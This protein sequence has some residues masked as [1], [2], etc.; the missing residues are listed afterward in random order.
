MG[1]QAVLPRQ[2]EGVSAAPALVAYLG[3]AG[4]GN[5]GDDAIQ[6]ALESAVPGVAFTDLPLYPAETAR[7]VIAPSGAR[8]IRNAVLLLGG[9]TVIGRSNWRV[10][11]RVAL[12]LVRTRP[13]IMIGSG[14]EDPAFQGRHSFAGPGELR[15][16]SN[17]LRSFE[18]V[19]VRGPRSAELLAGVGVDA[20]VVGDPALL[21]RRA[22]GTPAPEPGVIGVNLGYGDDMWGHDEDAVV[23]G[24][25][26]GLSQAIVSGHQVRFLVANKA[27][28]SQA[29]ACAAAAGLGNR[30][31]IRIA[32]APDKFLAEVSRCELF[33][34]ERLHAVVLATAAGIPSVMLEYQP[35]C[36]DFMQSIGRADWS[37]RTD[38]VQPGVLAEMITE[39]GSKRAE[40]ANEIERSVG[41]LRQVLAEETSTLQTLLS[42]QPPEERT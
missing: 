24:V 35:K 38:A 1:Q 37:I 41:R 9:G 39:L 5:L 13:G 8:Q 10:H 40:H 11:L 26:R 23:R 7:F 21:L 34:G 29:Q 16:W 6:Q 14:V 15:R 36:L 12:G 30:P 3:W 22:P 31:D 42:E 2:T 18:S 17:I 20:R 27:D 4:R 32:D 25:A 28:L 33:V 19:T